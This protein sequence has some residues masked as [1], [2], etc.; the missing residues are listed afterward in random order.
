VAAIRKRGLQPLKHVSGLG[1]IAT[2]IRTL[3]PL[4]LYR[5]S[6]CEQVAQI[7]H[8]EEVPPTILAGG[9][10]LCAKF[11]DGLVPRSLVALD[12]IDA[13]RQIERVDGEI[14]IGSSVTHAAGHADLLLNRQLSG[15][16]QTWGAIA[17]ARIRFRA[18]IGG[19]I[20][21][22]NPRYEMS[23]IL[24]ALGAMLSFRVADRSVRLSPDAVWSGDA[25]SRSFLEYIAIPVENDVLEFRYDRSLRLTMTLAV[26]MRSSKNRIE[27]RAAIATELL[28]PIALS[29]PKISSHQDLL[30]QSLASAAAATLPDDYTD[31]NTTNWYL[32]RA[33]ASVLR[34][35][36]GDIARA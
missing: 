30:S 2:S 3:A 28:A 34:R 21:A 10:D 11:N 24:N 29:F 26:C 14:R 33:A 36:L 4:R 17:N 19:N 1:L 13:L 12:R 27:L 25:P 35:R 31:G 7:L 18:T 9:T 32:R 20:M 6:T 5:P 8:N 15:F 23:V 22:L 16:A